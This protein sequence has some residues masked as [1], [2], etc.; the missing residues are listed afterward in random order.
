MAKNITIAING[1][2]RIGRCALKV[3]FEKKNITV[4][5]L[6]DLTDARTLAHLL[7]YDTA[8][9]KYARTVKATQDALI[10]DGKK[11]PVYAEKDPTAL[12]WKKLHV[13]VVL[14]CTGVVTSEEK[15]NAHVTAGAKRVVILV[16]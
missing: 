9:G 2:G 7:Q 12:P 1:F 16:P 15:A 8:Y 5:A 10:V 4:A 3:A 11:I 13:D 6:N 14:E